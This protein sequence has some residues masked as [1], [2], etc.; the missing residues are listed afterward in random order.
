MDEQKDTKLGTALR[1]EADRL[2]TPAQAYPRFKKARY[3]GS[4]IVE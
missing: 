1:K 3:E 2:W 4:S